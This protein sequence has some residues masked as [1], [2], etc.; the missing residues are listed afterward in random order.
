MS[1]PTTVIAPAAVATLEAG[2]FHEVGAAADVPLLE[3]RRATIDGRRVAIF[4]LPTGFAATDAAC[5]HRGGPLSDGL[6]ADGC[7][8]CPLHNWRLDL[9]SG[10]IGPDGDR[11]PIHDVVEE[12]GRLWVRLADVD[13]APSGGRHVA[14]TDPIADAA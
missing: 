1:D 10:A 3:G 11:M 7:V 6:V 13:V 12:G 5:P 4:R 9:T 2:G 14:A 8:T